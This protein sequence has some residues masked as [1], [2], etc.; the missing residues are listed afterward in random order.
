VCSPFNT[1]LKNPFVIGELQ[2][3]G[4]VSVLGDWQVLTKFFGIGSHCPVNCFLAG[5]QATKLYICQSSENATF[6]VRVRLVIDATDGNMLRLVS[7]AA[8]T[9]KITFKAA[10]V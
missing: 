6:T 1:T 4:V 3:Q 9:A 8:F 10:D 7:S 2:Q 5:I